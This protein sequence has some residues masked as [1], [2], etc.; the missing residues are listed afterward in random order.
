MEHQ[1]PDVGVYDPLRREHHNERGDADSNLGI[2]DAESL[3]TSGEHRVGST[4]WTVRFAL[5]C[6]ATSLWLHLRPSPGGGQR[7]A[8]AR[9]F[10]TLGCLAY[11]AHVATAFHFAHDW[12]HAR[13]YAHTADRTWELTGWRWGGGLYVNYLFTL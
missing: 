8:A 2:P 3:T 7:Q 6:Y 5:L 11:L 9:L 10:W 1:E 12:S 4:V 13:A